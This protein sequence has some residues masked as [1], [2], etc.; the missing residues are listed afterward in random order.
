MRVID[1][2]YLVSLVGFA[3][4]STS[5]LRLIP[6]AVQTYNQRKDYEA[7]RGL[8]L[9]TQWLTLA[10]SL[11]WIIYGVLLH[12]VSK[13]GWEALWIGAPSIINMPLAAMIIVL[14]SRARRA[15]A[16]V[17]LQD[18]DARARRNRSPR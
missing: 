7:L 9:A 4:T 10:N 18:G 3:A 13:T 5:L 17:R 2:V 12:L 16:L 15:D 1:P 11:L 8:S 14:T 6:Q